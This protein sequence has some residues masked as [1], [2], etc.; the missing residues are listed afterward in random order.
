MAENEESLRDQSI[1]ELVGSLSRDLST[2]VRQEIELAK[3]E[4]SEKAKKAGRGAGMFG[5]AGVAALLALIC[6]SVMAILILNAWMRD[7]LA[8]LIVT[9]VWAAVAGVLALRGREEL[10]QMGGPVPEQTQET[11]KEDIE[12]AKNPKRSATR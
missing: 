5:G 3:V 2:L 10:R 9:L 4:M 1:G 7:W 8:A 12:W 6:L 11:I